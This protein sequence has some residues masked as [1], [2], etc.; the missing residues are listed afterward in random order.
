MQAMGR[1]QI[2]AFFRKHR[3]ETYKKGHVLLLAG[4]CTKCAYYLVRGRVKQYDIT[5]QGSEITVNTFKSGDYFMIPTSLTSSPSTYYFSAATDVTIYCAPIEDTMVF[6][7]AQPEV[8]RDMLAQ[9]YVG[10]EGVL[11][12]MT[13]LMSGN[14]HG[15]VMYEIILDARDFGELKQG[16]PCTL[17]TNITEL[18]S[19]TGLSRE[20]VSR[21]VSRLKRQGLLV[22]SS[23]ITI[24]DLSLFEKALEESF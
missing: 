17:A 18:A 14:T 10:F 12:R 3:R 19:R 20:T 1:T 5:Y 2:D 7:N 11:Q 24:K 15:R 13:H 9:A 21:E 22:H 6:M 16:H 8:L 23:K 4:E